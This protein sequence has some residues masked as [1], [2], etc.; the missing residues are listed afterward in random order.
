MKSINDFSNQTILSN[1]IIGR[2]PSINNNKNYISSNQ[3][4]S[5]NSNEKIN[6]NYRNMKNNNIN[7]NNFINKTQT[8]S[9]E[10]SKSKS[11]SRDEIY[12]TNKILKSNLKFP[13]PNEKN[14]FA[15]QNSSKNNTQRNYQINVKIYEKAIDKLFLYMKSILP[16]D[17][18]KN[19]KLKFLNDILKE[20][21][22]YNN[23]ETI[24]SSIT[25]LIKST[26]SNNTI[27]LEDYIIQNNNNII[28]NEKEKIKLSYNDYKNINLIKKHSLYT[29][30]KNKLLNNK[31][32]SNSKS[33]SKSESKSPNNSKGRNEF[34]KSV[35]N[36]KKNYIK[37]YNNKATLNS[38]LFEKINCELLKIDLNPISKKK[39]NENNNNN[40]KNNKKS[41]SPNSKN[42]H[43]RNYKINNISNLINS[44]ENNNYTTG[45]SLKKKEKHTK[46]HFSLNFKNNYLNKDIEKK[47][48]SNIIIKEIL[49]E[50]KN[51][52][53][54]KEIKSSLDE[55]LK[56]MFN[57]SY[58]D[59]LNKESENDSKK[60]MEDINNNNN[61][62]KGVYKSK[63]QI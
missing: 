5:F 36:T 32:M 9:K 53:Q 60:S 63:Y 1:R 31:T 28:N 19:I 44:N 15:I 4:L 35:R 14:N 20:Y 17:I 48:N 58:E 38:K 55:T 57:F 30:S 42:S 33:K 37:K 22:N 40:I 26:I 34:N 7:K 47:N 25:N 43:N 11:K 6:K 49:N 8:Q 56:I 2:K 45:N 51:S 41:N 54:L 52:E 3:T 10:K 39:I 50:S 27:N 59:F 23:E 21:N 18:Y 62:S 12:F 16:Y 61:I 29:L 24:K 46:S 13:E